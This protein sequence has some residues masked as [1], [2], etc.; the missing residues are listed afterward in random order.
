MSRIYASRF[1]N[2][3]AL[4]VLHDCAICYGPFQRQHVGAGD[5]RET[6]NTVTYGTWR[7]LVV[8]H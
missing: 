7:S 3:G 1:D 4:G 8:L 6:D 5:R 2:E